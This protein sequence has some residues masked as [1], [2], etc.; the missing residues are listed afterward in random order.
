[1]TKYIIAGGRDFYDYALLEKEAKKLDIAEVVCGMARGADM[2]GFKY[3]KES[4][5]PVTEFPAQW[6]TY[7]P[8]AGVMRNCDMG[9]YAD[10]LLAFWDGKSSGTAHM[11]N[12]MRKLQK[13]VILVSY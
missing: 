11:I 6:E 2:L 13:P 1:M 5:L 8:R 12:Y 3:A 4:D 7:G 10:A 9:D